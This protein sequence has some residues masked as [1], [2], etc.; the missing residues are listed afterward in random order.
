[1]KA[2]FCR[3]TEPIGCMYICRKRFIIRLA[4]VIMEAVQLKICSVGREAGHPI[5]QMVQIK[6]E[7]SLPTNS[8]LPVFSFYSGLQEIG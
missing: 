3:E 6:S 2:L 8:L 5:E 4:H 7:G 1:M